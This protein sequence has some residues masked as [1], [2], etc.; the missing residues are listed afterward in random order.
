LFDRWI[1]HRCRCEEQAEGCKYYR[2]RVTVVRMRDLPDA[3]ASKSILNHAMH[4][5]RVSHPPV[6]FPLVPSPY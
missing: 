3:V 6:N 1:C 4:S 5:L 2:E